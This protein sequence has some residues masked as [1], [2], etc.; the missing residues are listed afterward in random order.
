[1]APLSKIRRSRR[2]RAGLAAAICFTC[3]ATPAL[4]TEQDASDEGLEITGLVLD[5]TKTKLGADFFDFF[6][7]S[8][9]EVAGLEYTIAISELP[10]TAR[11]GSFF[12]VTVDEAHVYSKLLQP[13]LERLEAAAEE[14]RAAVGV[15]LLK[16]LEQKRL[17]QEEEEFQ[18]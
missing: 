2:P 9:Q 16:E 5:E 12:V 7:G 4:S 3:L 18:F 8:W 13:R 6:T 1:M 11:R 15:H 10:A 17:L 14:A